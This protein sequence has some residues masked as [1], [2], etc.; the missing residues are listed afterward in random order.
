MGRTDDLFTG[1]HRQAHQGLTRAF[2]CSESDGAG[3]GSAGDAR[4]ES[5]TKV[6]WS[7]RG[8]VRNL[9]DGM[10]LEVLEQHL[11][12]NGLA[13]EFIELEVTECAVMADPDSCIRLITLLRNR[14]FGV[15]ID[16]VGV[17]NSSLA[18]L[19]KL[20]VFI[21]KIDQVF[22]LT[23]DTDESNQKVVRSI[24]NLAK[25]LGLETVADG[26]ET[27]PMANLLR[28]WGCDYGQGYAFHLPAPAQ[29]LM[30]FL[31]ECGKGQG[32][33]SAA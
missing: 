26:V 10:L 20:R 12:E 9:H 5:T 15:S 7:R 13:P 25:S 4:A 14:G 30:R 8:D 19:Q 16:D 28:E 1:L 24:L 29:E 11:S 27:M 32:R 2:F 21:L 6:I 23:L 33:N 22:I 17:G 18:Y 3:R 31:H